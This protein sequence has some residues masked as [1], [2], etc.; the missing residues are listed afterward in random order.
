MLRCARLLLLAV[1]SSLVAGTASAHHSHALYDMTQSDHVAGTIAKLEW[2][3]PHIFVWLYAPDK[4]AKSGYQLYAFESGSVALMARAGWNHGS[5]TA[6]EKVAVDY[7]PLRDGRPGGAL[8]KLTRPD[9]RSLGGDPLL[10]HAFQ[11]SA[12]DQK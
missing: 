7:I 1:S 10:V 9:G 5:L 6:G 12:R 11:G 3:N 8:L 2:T 4:K